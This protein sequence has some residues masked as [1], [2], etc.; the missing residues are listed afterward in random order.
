M[1]LNAIREDVSVL[2]AVRCGRVEALRRLQAHTQKEK[3]FYH[4]TIIK[5]SFLFVFSVTQHR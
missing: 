2:S 3:G 4:L 5:A 1:T